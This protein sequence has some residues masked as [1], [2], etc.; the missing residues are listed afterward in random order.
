MPPSLCL[1]KLCAIE[2]LIS[3]DK[4][5][6]GHPLIAHVVFSVVLWFQVSV[7][8]AQNPLGVL[9]MYQTTEIRPGLK[10]EEDFV[11]QHY[12]GMQKLYMVFPA[13]PRQYLTCGPATRQ[14]QLVAV[15]FPSAARTGRAVTTQAAR[16]LTGRRLGQRR[17]IW[18]STGLTQ[19]IEKADSA[20]SV[21]PGGRPGS[22]S[23][24]T[25]SECLS[26]AMQRERP[27]PKPKRDQQA[28]LLRL[29]PPPCSRR[30]GVLYGAGFA[31]GGGEGA[32]LSAIMAWSWAGRQQPEALLVPAAEHLVNF[33]CS[34]RISKYNLIILDIG[35]W[36]RSEP[37]LSYI[38]VINYF[39]L[40]SYHEYILRIFLM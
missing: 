19:V 12:I 31:P 32:H 17:L 38:E 4:L 18:R 23:C 13:L 30:E 22:L 15:A 3:D 14:H 36:R 11:I 35:H 25:P 39:Y 9:N 16:G 24:P 5:A 8:I 37:Y 20:G 6:H 29:P 34:L 21:G 26:H 1:R 7:F 10:I 27:Y 28:H 2:Q 33:D 40:L